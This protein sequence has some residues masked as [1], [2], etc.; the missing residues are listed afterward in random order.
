MARVS[1]T[2]YYLF[3]SVMYHFL[4]LPEGS[5]VYRFFM[6]LPPLKYKVQ[7]IGT[8]LSAVPRTPEYNLEHFLLKPHP[9]QQVFEK[10][11]EYF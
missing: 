5:L 3:S 7:E 2:L 4:K 11:G 1:F 8:S 6:Y 10:L 9:S